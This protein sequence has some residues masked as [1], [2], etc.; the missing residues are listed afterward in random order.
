LGV[1]SGCPDKATKRKKGP[2]I[3]HKPII[4]RVINFTLLLD[5]A[6]QSLID[7]LPA[8]MAL[9]KS[10]YISELILSITLKKLEIV[11]FIIIAAFVLEVKKKYSPTIP[12]EIMI[13]VVMAIPFLPFSL[14]HN[15]KFVARQTL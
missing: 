1:D 11:L 6:H 13:K 4:E 9:A 8:L 12:I 5:L 3:K 2:K 14:R 10:S 15:C 7:L